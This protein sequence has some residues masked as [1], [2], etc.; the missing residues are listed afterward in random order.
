MKTIQEIPIEIKNKPVL[1]NLIAEWYRSPSKALM[2]YIDNSFDSSDDFFNEHGLYDRDVKIEIEINRIEHKITIKDNCEGMNLEVLKGLADNIND[3]EKK[4][5]EQK[6]PWVNGQFGLGAHAFRFFAQKLMIFSK[7][8]GGN[9]IALLIDRDNPNAE[10]K[11]C[12]GEID[13]KNLGNSGTLVEII[14]IDKTHLKNLKPDELKNEIE[15]YFEMLLRRNVEIT[16]RDDDIKAI[17]TPFN[18]DE[19]NGIDI[20]KEI[21]TWRY[22]TSTVTVAEN[23]GIKVN[24][25]I[26]ANQINRPP[27]FSRKGRKINYIANL[28]S[29]ISK[30]RH[31][32]KVW[33]NYY[34]TGYIEVGNNLEPVLARDDFKGGKGFS[35]KRT[36]IY[37]EIVKL[38]DEIHDAIEKINKDRS[39]ENLKSLASVLTT[40]L[41]EISKEDEIKLRYENKSGKENKGEWVKVSPNEDAEELYKVTKKN[42]CKKMIR[43]YEN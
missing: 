24:L 41:T 37:E 36:G 31:R 32:K 19:I 10:L 26:C 42:S 28:S 11:Q 3:S 8:K 2:E 7:Q 34:L 16:V 9:Q 39:D 23:N 17:C 43:K 5:R 21:V 40:F 4:R 14:D 6:R 22:G 27:F 20:K 29:F 13:D 30:T 38:E 12:E 33:E 18:Y 25:K 1:L 35:L 15:T